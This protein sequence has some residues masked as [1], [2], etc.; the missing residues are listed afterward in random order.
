MTTSDE[1][2]G[3]LDRYMQVLELVATFPGALTLADVSS[4]LDLP[5]TSAHRLLKGLVR[6]GLAKDSV[7][8][9]AY[10]L[11]DRLLRLLHAT[12]DD[13]WIAA[14]ARA[15]LQQL[16]DATSET[17]YLTRLI[18]ARVVVAISISPDVRWR[19]YVQPG[20]EMPVHAAATAKAI[21]AYQSKAILAEAMSGELPLLTANT[22][23]DRKWIEQELA[24]VRS[25]GHATCI[26]EIDEGL[27]AIAVPIF[28]SDRRVFYALGMTGPLQRIMNEQLPDRLT[29]L[30][31]VAYVL[32]NALSIGEKLKS[33]DVAGS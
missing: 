8:G 6:A 25:R 4:L 14:L 28:L 33:K 27:A 22:R 2:A 1:T 18:G 16:T 10:Q 31:N 32:G 7:G 15:H 20:I 24:T 13:G 5:K 19:S 29:A 17:C 12:A 3:P 26:G 30:S 23:N 21:I 9:R 11:G